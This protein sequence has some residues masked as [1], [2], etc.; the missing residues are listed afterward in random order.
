MADIFNRPSTPAK[1]NAAPQSEA[2][3]P[4]LKGKAR[5]EAKKGGPASSSAIPPSASTP[6]KSKNFLVNSKELLALANAIVDSKKPVQVPADII[7]AGLR[8]VSARKRSAAFFQNQTDT[9]DTETAVGNEGHSYFISLME[10]VLSALQPCFSIAAGAACTEPTSSDNIFRTL[11]NRFAT[12]EV[13]EPVEPTTGPAPKPAAEQPLYE[14][15]A[16]EANKDEER[17]FAI[18][19]LFDDL[20]RLRTFVR[21]LW[22]QF[23]LRKVDLITASVTTNTAFQLAIRAQDET[24]VDF[25]ASADYQMVLGVI[26]SYYAKM[27]KADIQEGA[28]GEIE[29]DD[30]VAEVSTVLSIDRACLFWDIGSYPCC[31]GALGRILET[32]IPNYEPP[33]KKQR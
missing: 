3:A 27:Q 14:L 9:D 15:D 13:E 8:A 20:A 23:K 16:Q 21:N 25:P 19:C 6:P 22:E 18:F 4:R 32:H 12:L 31:L 2:K 24:L 33:Q 7:R 29:M 17:L 26:I 11:E 28:E 5:K 30:G 1:S 10:Q